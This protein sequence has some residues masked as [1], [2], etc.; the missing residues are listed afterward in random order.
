MIA[1]GPRQRFYIQSTQH[2]HNGTVE[3]R[4]V[5]PE[6]I[7]QELPRLRE[8][9]GW[10]NVN[11][12]EFSNSPKFTPRYDEWVDPSDPSWIQLSPEALSM[13]LLRLAYIAAIGEEGAFNAFP[14]PL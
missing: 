3:Y 4:V 5:V 10:F 9:C 7:M 6:V 11:N 2:V 14:T 12:I 13:Q 8:F 1:D